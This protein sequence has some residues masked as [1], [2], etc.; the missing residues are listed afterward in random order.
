MDLQDNIFSAHSYVHVSLDTVSAVFY[1]LL[2]AY[3]HCQTCIFVSLCAQLTHTVYRWITFTQTSAY[4]LPLAMCISCTEPPVC[5]PMH[6][7]D[8]FII[9]KLVTLHRPVHSCSTPLHRCACQTT[10]IRVQLLAPFIRCTLVCQLVTGRSMSLSG[11]KVTGSLHYADTFMYFRK[12][13]K[14]ALV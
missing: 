4:L 14:S 1:V 3:I 12:I 2:F 6:T 7:S 13:I 9:Y 8:Y 5:R 11:N 10:S